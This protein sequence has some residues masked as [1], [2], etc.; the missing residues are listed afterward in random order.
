MRNLEGGGEGRG[1]EKI[2]ISRIFRRRKE[3]KGKG[4]RRTGRRIFR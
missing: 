4:R 1:G 2:E 3:G